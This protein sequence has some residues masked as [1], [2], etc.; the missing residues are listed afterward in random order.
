MKLPRRRFLHL[1]AGAAALP[2]L[3][4]IGWAQTYPARPVRMIVPFAPGGT[5]DLFAR[6]AAQKLSEGLGKQFYVENI[7]GASGNVATGQV[8][9]AAPDGYTVLVAFSSHVVNPTLFDKIPYDPY[10]DFESVILAVSATTVLFVNPSV[11]ARTVKELVDLIRASPGKFSFASPGA[12]TPA[13]LAG[14]HLRQLLKLD[15]VHVPYNG[16]G[17]S[18]GSVVAGH[19]P[20]GFT[21][22]AAAGQY[23][24]A[25]T[26][27]ALA[28]TS[29]TRSQVQ[30]VVP[31]MVESGYPEI[32][33]DNW[34]GILVP[35]RTRDRQDHRDARH[36]GTLDNARFRYGGKHARGVRLSHQ[37]R[38]RKV[39]P[40]DQSRPY[41]AAVKQTFRRRFDQPQDRQGVRPRGTA[42]AHRPR[43]RGDRIRECEREEPR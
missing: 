8:A 32:E 30:P 21:T 10:K 34:V 35:A 41:Q 12:G 3:L 23:I 7:P 9:R 29:K 4:R 40:R 11:P 1:A 19:S 16:A 31:T 42:D 22:I 26:L 14:E 43:R 6:L 13:H 24:K 18:V 39:G 28:V 17:P 5:T 36:E 20:I 15:L 37:G 2:A 27:R 38:D 25:G 33:G